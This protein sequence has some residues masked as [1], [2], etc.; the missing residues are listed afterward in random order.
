VIETEVTKDGATLVLTV[1]ELMIINNALNEICNG[2]HIADSEFQTRIAVERD[3]AR[4]VLHR[5]NGAWRH[6]VSEQR[7]S[8]AGR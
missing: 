5:I 6:A 4:A 8:Q 7:K 2:I 1:D 3:E